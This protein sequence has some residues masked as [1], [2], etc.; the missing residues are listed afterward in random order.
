[1]FAFGDMYPQQTVSEFSVYLGSIGIIRHAKASHEAS[2]CSFDAMILPAFFILLD[3]SLA[4]NLE[5]AILQR[6]LHVVFVYLRQFCRDQV[7]LVILCDVH[8]RGPFRRRDI[9]LSIAPS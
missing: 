2:I 5:D 9:L 6:D 4:L 8:E 7:F 1:M 3:L